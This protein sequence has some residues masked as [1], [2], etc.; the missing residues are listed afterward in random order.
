M[1]FFQSDQNMAF[2]RN[3]GTRPIY[4]DISPMTSKYLEDSI[5]HSKVSPLVSNVNEGDCFFF[6]K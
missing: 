2:C 1:Q 5:M 3:T 6:I 4:N